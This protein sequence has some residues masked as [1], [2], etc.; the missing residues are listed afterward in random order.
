MWHV[1]ALTRSLEDLGAALYP[2]Q[3]HSEVGPAAAGVIIGL[4]L[5]ADECGQVS[6]REGEGDAWRR[7]EEEGH[8]PLSLVTPCLASNRNAAW[9]KHP[10]F[11]NHVAER[12]GGMHVCGALRS[13]YAGA[14]PAL[15]LQRSID[16]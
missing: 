9:Q 1:V 10:C 13:L 4:R 2:P 6:E 3:E 7:Q 12:G 14:R 11:I 15:G 8:T 5:L 16:Q